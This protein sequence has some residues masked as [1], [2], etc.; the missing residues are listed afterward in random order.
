M[1]LI[2]HITSRSLA[3]AARL[4]GEYRTESLATQGFIHFSQAHQVLRT[5]NSFYKGRTDLVILG[6]DTQRLKAELK[7]EAPVHPTG[8]VVPV[9][10]AGQIEPG[11]DG[12]EAAAV[13][14]ASPQTPAAQDFPH[15]YGALNFE[16]VVKVIDLP[17][18]ADGSF[19]LP[20][21][22]TSTD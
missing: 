9:R 10:F 18:N 12:F 5:A 22:S 6:V 17:L 20:A 1:S 15:L 19:D 7:Y 2:Y 16:A 3:E 4:S 14:T 8:E 21:L 13:V 11:S